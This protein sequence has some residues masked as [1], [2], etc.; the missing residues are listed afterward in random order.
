MVAMYLGRFITQSIFRHS[1]S[2]Y[3]SSSYRAASPSAAVGAIS[4]YGVNG[5][6][7]AFFHQTYVI[8][9]AIA[10]PVEENKIAGARLVAFRLPLV[11]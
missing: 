1:I 10:A 9:V 11:M 7:V 3:L 4:L 6:A 2:V 5:L 8:R